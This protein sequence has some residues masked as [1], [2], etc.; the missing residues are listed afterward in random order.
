MWPCHL[1]I[2]CQ[3]SEFE[4]LAGQPLEWSDLRVLRRHGEKPVELYTRWLE[5]HLAPWYTF[6]RSLMARWA[7][8]WLPPELTKPSSV[9]VD[10]LGWHS[11]PALAGPEREYR[12]QQGY[13]PY[14]MGGFRSWTFSPLEDRALREIISVCRCRGIVL[15]L[16]YMP[17]GTDFQSW[18][19]PALRTAADAYLTRLSKETAVPLINA[20]DW[21]PDSAFVDSFHLSCDGAQAFTGALRPRGAPAT[22]RTPEFRARHRVHVSRSEYI[23][24]RCAPGARNVNVATGAGLDTALDHGAVFSSAFTCSSLSGLSMASLRLWPTWME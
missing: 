15:T 4:R 10:R 21:M 11:E 3:D 23:I 9:E 5:E 14:F 1:S 20:R 19:P 6:R 2:G 16:L 18:Y 17:E 22:A 7:S 12:V 8:A 13:R 24:R